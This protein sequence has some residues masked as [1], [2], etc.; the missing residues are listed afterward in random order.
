MPIIAD[1]ASQEILFTA[2]EKGAVHDF[3][4]FK[5]TLRALLY[6]ILLLADSG[7]QG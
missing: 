4:L 6:G 3:Q 7:D 2:Q 1:V 5:A